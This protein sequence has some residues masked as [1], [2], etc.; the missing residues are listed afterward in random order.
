MASTHGG[1]VL[2][3]LEGNDES[4]TYTA[5]YD[6]ETTS[7]SMAVVGAVAGALDTDPLDL[8]PLFE[9]V[10]TDAL[11]GLLGEAGNGQANVS[12]TFA[13]CEIEMSGDG[14]IRL[15]VQAE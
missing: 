8:D 3:S 6:Q 14:E 5:T 4:G 10:E 12:F 13:D 2:D 11:D 1:I 9:T 15:A 7:P